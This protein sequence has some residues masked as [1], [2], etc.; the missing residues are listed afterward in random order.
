MKKLRPYHPDMKKPNK[1]DLVYLDDSPDYCES[2]EGLVLLDMENMYFHICIV[3]HI[4]T[5]QITEWTF[6]VLMVAY[7]TGQAPDL[8]DVDYSAAVEA[9]KQ[10]SSILTKSAN[11][12]S[13]GAAM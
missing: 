4:I 2:N 9:I 8:M 11:V 1:T 5:F 10:E 13:S 7:A 3:S 12:D 6:W